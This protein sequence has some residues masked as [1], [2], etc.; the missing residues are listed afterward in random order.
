MPFLLRNLILNLDEEETLL[1]EKVIARFDLDRDDLLEL[2]V[3]RKGIDAR[4]KG[5]IKFVCTVRITL[6]DE[7][8]FL[9]RHAA[10][11]DLDVTPAAPSVTFHRVT[12]RERII[13]VGAG[14]AGLFAAVR[15]AEHGLPAT[16]IERGK[17]VEERVRDVAAFWDKGLL[18]EESNVQFGEGG[19][20]TFSDGKLTTRI[21]DENLRYVLTKLVAYGA[22]DDILY[23]ARPHI[24]TDRLRTVIANLRQ[25]L[26]ARGMT[27]LFREKLTGLTRSGGR[28]CAITTGN[29]REFPCD[30]L[31]LAPGHS[32]RDTYR[33][34][35]NHEVLLEAKP[36]AVG[37]RVEHPQEMIDLIQYG[38]SRHPGLPPADYFLTYNNRSSG[39]AAYSFCMCPGGEVVAA[40]SESGGVV[41]NGMSSYRRSSP[42]ANSALVVAVDHRDFP[43]TPLAGIEFQREL[44]RS[45]FR[46][47]GGGYHAPA[48][49][50][51]S[52]LGR[53]GEHPPVSTYR[54]GVVAADLALLLPPAVTQTLREGI[55]IFNDRMRGFITAEATLV[56][57]E[58]RT[59]APVRIV[60]N[61]DC[62]SVT[63]PG[64]YPAGEGAGYAGGIM[65][66]AIDGIRVADAIVARLSG[67]TCRQS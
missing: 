11:P 53:K 65:S 15:L 66:A 42:F 49:N 22:P 1:R 58:T 34:L 52:F 28:L 55:R 31:I 8:G 64:L 29:D 18:D 38:R 4:K 43:P 35:A 26:Q 57:V 36:F 44:E 51:L 13:I 46:A 24:G 59:S 47:G 17:P 2:R 45:A 5:A 48:Q 37:V 63:L 10:D 25:D 40:A 54:P 32:A 14:P 62:Q 9:A 6:A 16:L 23:L 67:S 21:R 56:G 20:G 27:F 39:R 12:A 7:P 50:L 33:M 30:S 60:R 61:A 41:T 3:V 19:A